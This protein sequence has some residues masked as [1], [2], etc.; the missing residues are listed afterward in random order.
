MTLPDTTVL[1]TRVGACWPG[2]RAVFRGLDLHRDLAGAGSMDL[3]LFGIT[4]RRFGA[5][6][7]R[8]LDGMW[9]LT[10]YPD[11][12]LWN[13]RVAAL[14]AN[15]RSLPSLALAAGLA[16]SEARVFGG[17]PAFF[18]IE[19]LLR[20]GERQRAGDGVEAIVADELARQR[21]ILGY[22]R[23]IHATDER[24]PPLLAL[25]GREG[26]ADGP[27]LRLALDIEQVLLRR[28]S[29]LKLNYAGATA[30]LAADLG[31]TARQYQL[32][33]VFKTMLGMPPCVVE[34]AEKPEGTL[35]PTACSQV[36]YEGHPSRCWTARGRAA[37]T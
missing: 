19:F 3:F 2:T 17:G 29:F 14:A 34:A 10:G 37:P 23:P 33:N 8:L 25:A 16:A 4:G 28:K 12:R 21:R 32:Y 30:A 20:A 22:G 36:V 7:L 5:H 26:L 1:R 13:N 31:L 18:A 11:T 15:A 35:M 6:E 27:H 9:A 24:L